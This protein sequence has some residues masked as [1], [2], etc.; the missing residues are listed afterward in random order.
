MPAFWLGLNWGRKQWISLEILVKD[1]NTNGPFWQ[2]TDWKWYF[3]LTF[4]PVRPLTCGWWLGRFLWSCTATVG[5]SCGLLQLSRQVEWEGTCGTWGAT[6]QGGQEGE[7]EGSEGEMF[8]SLGVHVVVGRVEFL[9]VT[10]SCVLLE[11][12]HSEMMTGA[13]VWWAGGDHAT[14]HTRPDGGHGRHGSQQWINMA[15]SCS[16]TTTV[17]V[18]ITRM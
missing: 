7:G 10:L 3:L 8:V 2:W 18:L 16:N 5:T 1:Q 9:Q 6:R 12:W 17:T 14:S 11:E 15:L 13:V 4:L